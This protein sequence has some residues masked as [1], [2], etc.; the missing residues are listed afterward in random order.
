LPNGNLDDNGSVAIPYQAG[1]ERL[2]DDGGRFAA[3]V[4]MRWLAAIA[5][6]TK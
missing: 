2:E 6:P 3:D 1:I 4:I 5:I